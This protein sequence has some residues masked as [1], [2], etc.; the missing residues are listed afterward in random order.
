MKTVSIVNRSI[1]KKLFLYIAVFTIVVSGITSAMQINSNYRDEF[2]RLQSEINRI[3]ELYVQT[4][5]KSVW[6]MDEEQIETQ[7]RS[8]LFMSF[9][10]SA[11][12]YTGDRILWQ[13]GKSGGIRNFNISVPL[14]YLSEGTLHDL[15]R[16]GIEIDDSEIRQS[17]KGCI[18]LIVITNLL[19]TFFISFFSFF[20]VNRLILRH[21]NFISGFLH[22]TDIYDPEDKLDFKNKKA[23][24]DELDFLKDSIN[25]MKINLAES[26]DSQLSMMKLADEANS[27]NRAKSLFLANMSHEIRTPMNAILGFS[28][29][30]KGKETDREK[31]H[32]IESIH[33]SGESLLSLINDI[34]DLSKI[35]SGKQE[36]HYTLASMKSLLNTL[37]VLFHQKAREKDLSLQFVFDER[38][39]DSL[40]LDIVHLKQVLINIINNAIKFTGSGFV[41]INVKAP[42]DEPVLESPFTLLI[43]VSDSGIGIPEDQQDA[44]FESFEQVHDKDNLHREGTGLGLAISKKLTVMMGG[45]IGLESRPGEGSLFRI[46]LPGV[47]IGAAAV[48]DDH[49]LNYEYNFEPALI[50]IADDITFNCEI[51]EAYLKPYGFELLFCDN[52]ED[53]IRLA[54]EKTPDLILMDMKMPVVNGYEATRRIK[55]VS[56]IPVIAITASAL[57]QEEKII[58]GLCDGYLRKPV[59]KKQ[60]LDEISKFIPHTRIESAIS[61]K[62]GGEGYA[63]GTASGDLFSGKPI[64]QDWIDT[65]IDLSETGKS[66]ELIRFAE[67]LPDQWSNLRNFLVDNA[68]SYNF[69]VILRNLQRKEE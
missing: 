12:V 7:L 54:G 34:L 36:V 66:S 29:I 1:S 2:Q 69:E 18:L 61:P 68:E 67:K 23:A 37:E 17:L 16:F 20:L 13:S 8:L 46:T 52:G 19:T 56:S 49:S 3:Q 48:T 42:G 4:L 35:E 14:E 58:S 64:P 55:K 26:M 9:I 24:G 50:L 41:K 40:V 63:D 15:G 21:L 43:E 33:T 39:P 22:E 6:L 27:A 53:V 30:L 32:F 59:S 31:L 5:T 47:N 11:A 25:D 62:G 51:M 44:V 38:I 60:L 10:K 28:E 65:I 45:T 57:L